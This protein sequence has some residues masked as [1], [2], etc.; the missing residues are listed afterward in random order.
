MKEDQGLVQ[1]HAEHSFSHQVLHEVLHELCFYSLFWVQE[2]H[3]QKA[4]NTT[5]IL[6]NLVLDVMGSVVHST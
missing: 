2:D 4:L 5:Q 1:R 6:S 3:L